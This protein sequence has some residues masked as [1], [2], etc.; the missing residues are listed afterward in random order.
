VA[1]DGGVFRST[2]GAESWH[3]FERGLGRL[4]VSALAFAP[5]GR[6]FFA[7]TRGRGVVDFTLGG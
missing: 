7:G 1:G 4:G 5:D 2:D 6:T 3:R